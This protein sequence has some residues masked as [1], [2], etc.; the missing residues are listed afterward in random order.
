MLPQRAS[1]GGRRLA[2]GRL[3]R[4]DLVHDDVRQRALRM[5]RGIRRL[6]INRRTM[7]DNSRYYKPI[8][9]RLGQDFVH[10]ANCDSYD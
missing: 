8:S 9:S 1:L 3:L 10:T 6:Q 7:D 4:A 5:P 2:H